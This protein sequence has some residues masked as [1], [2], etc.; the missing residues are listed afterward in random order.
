MNRKIGWIRDFELYEDEHDEVDMEK[1]IYG[2][3]QLTEEELNRMEELADLI[4][5][6][7][8]LT[9]EMYDRIPA[10]WKEDAIWKYRN[11][12]YEASKQLTDELVDEMRC[13]IEIDEDAYFTAVTEQED[14]E[15]GEFGEYY[16]EVQKRY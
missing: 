13:Y 12:L 8:K 5:R 3:K 7:N 11:K 16:K 9:K 15:R 2:D 4:D 1:F 6:Q 10:H 14:Y